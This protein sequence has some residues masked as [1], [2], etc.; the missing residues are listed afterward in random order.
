MAI[1]H[2]R[3]VSWRNATDRSCPPEIWLSV[4]A[5]V[6]RHAVACWEGSR[7]LW[8]GFYSGE[9]LTSGNLVTRV[10]IEIPNANELRVRGIDPQDLIR[11]AI[12]AGRFAGRFDAHATVDLI[13]ASQWKGQVKK[14]LSHWRIWQALSRDEKKLLPPESLDR[15]KKGL[16][17]GP[18]RWSGHNLFDAV[19]IGLWHCKRLVKGVKQDVLLAPLSVSC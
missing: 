17:G 15:I 14:P 5:G 19:G 1:G 2:G 13:W 10:V 8:V 3:R 7:L 11:L 9:P 12:A 6:Q 18:Y 16:K 4:D